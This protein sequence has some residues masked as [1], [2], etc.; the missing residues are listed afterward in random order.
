MLGDEL[1]SLLLGRRLAFEQIAQVAQSPGGMGA[2][3]AQAC[4][5]APL[6]WRCVRL[7]S[8]MTA[9]RA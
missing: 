2:R 4:S 8:P 6:A 5:T 9:R 1:E 7:T 3:L